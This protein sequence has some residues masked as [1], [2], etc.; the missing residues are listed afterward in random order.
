M[1]MLSFDRFFGIVKS[2]LVWGTDGNDVLLLITKAAQAGRLL[3]LLTPSAE[4]VLLDLV[5]DQN[6]HVRELLLQMI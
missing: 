3:D 2:I 4:K 6:W 1:D 5:F